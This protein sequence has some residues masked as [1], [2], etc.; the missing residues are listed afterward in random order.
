[1]R[2]LLQREGEHLS[3]KQ[4]RDVDAALAALAQTSAA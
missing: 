1:M 2:D 4:R 3:P